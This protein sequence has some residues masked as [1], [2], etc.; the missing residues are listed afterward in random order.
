MSPSFS[1]RPIADWPKLAP[2]V[3]ILKLCHTVPEPKSGP[4]KRT[5]AKDP[6]NLIFN[7]EVF[8]PLGFTDDEVRPFAQYFQET[9][10]EKIHHDGVEIESVK[11]YKLRQ[12]LHALAWSWIP[13]CK[14]QPYADASAALLK[15][16]IAE[17]KNRHGLPNPPVAIYLLDET[18]KEM[19][20][21]LTEKIKPPVNQQLCV[22][23]WNDLL[24]P[25]I[26]GMP[27]TMGRPFDREHGLV[28]TLQNEN[29][30]T[31]ASRMIEAWEIPAFETLVDTHLRDHFPERADL[32]SDNYYDFATFFAEN[33]GTLPFNFDA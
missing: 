20:A 4:R 10:N 26:P 8:G 7:H 18:L 24:Y 6:R 3:R 13:G 11:G 27:A 23:D 29:G 16:L 22:I 30:E 25:I 12:V 2:L 33:D 9:E 21:E 17:I 15:M 32:F 14:G 1:F 28:L 5:L 31:K 19:A